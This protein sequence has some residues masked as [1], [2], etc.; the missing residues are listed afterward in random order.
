MRTDGTVADF[1]EFRPKTASTLMGRSIQK[2]KV[3]DID[4][5]PQK[6]VRGSQSS[7]HQEG[8]RQRDTNK[9]LS[10]KEQLGFEGFKEEDMRIRDEFKK[11][12][13]DYGIKKTLLE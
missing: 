9:N 6:Y 11:L 5:E 12:R 3:R 10:I 13:G 8:L 1:K 4:Y 7:K 2:R